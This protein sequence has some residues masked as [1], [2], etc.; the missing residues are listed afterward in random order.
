MKTIK[1]FSIIFVLSIV[2]FACTKTETIYT[3]NATI[4]P[5]NIVSS[6][7]TVY[8]SSANLTYRMTR[9]SPCHPS[10]EIFYD[11]I[12]STNFPSNAEYKWEFG[13]GGTATGNYVQHMYEYWNVYTVKLTVYV[14]GTIQQV[15]TTSV[16]PYGQHA[17]PFAVYG[18]QLNDYKNPNWVAF[19]AQTNITTG[20][21]VNYS[22]DWKDGTTSSVATSYTE[23]LFPE[24]N[25][26]KYYKVKMTATSHAGCKDS[27]DDSTVFVPA[28]YTNVGGI[29]YTKTNACIDSE[30]ITFTQSTIGLPAN[31]KFEW[32][33]GEGIRY[34]GN[35]LTHHFVY[36][37]TYPVVC[38]TVYMLWVAILNLYPI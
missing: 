32:D 15:L 26:D 5:G 21:I 19:N 16:K 20:S 36:T 30:M 31:A 13:D 24:L 34:W 28:S 10:N 38:Y 9:T 3:P 17:T 27:F 29:T 22:W 14:N 2:L 33:L 23:H 1:S 6:G 12:I 37:K 18:C 11:S 7:D 8:V 25:V 35:P 4:I